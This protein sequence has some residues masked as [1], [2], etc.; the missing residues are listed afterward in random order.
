MRKSR[1]YSNPGYR[2]K[3]WIKSHS[4]AYNYLYF[5]YY[6]GLGDRWANRPPLYPLLLAALR[7]VGRRREHGAGKPREA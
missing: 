2:F 5:Y 3:V 6:F 4:I 7:V 1:Y